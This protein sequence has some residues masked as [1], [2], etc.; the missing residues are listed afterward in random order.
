VAD[1]KAAVKKVEEEKKADGN[2]SGSGNGNGNGSGAVIEEKKD[3]P[4][5]P[6][7]S[8]SWFPFFG[9]AKLSHIYIHTYIQYI[10]CRHLVIYIFV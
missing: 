6:A 2:G 5:I 1:K 4:P 8:N 3:E 10:Y 9:Y 7:P